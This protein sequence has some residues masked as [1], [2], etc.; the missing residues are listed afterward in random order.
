MAKGSSHDG[1]GCRRMEDIPM[2]NSE[3]VLIAL[4]KQAQNKEYQFHRIYRNLCI[5]DMYIKAYSNIYGNKGS[6]TPGTDGETA[7]GFSE[8][9][10]NRIIDSLKDE[11]YQ[12]T[13]LRRAYIPKKN[14]KLRPLG[15]PSFTDRV[16]QEV[17][18]MILEAIY[19]PSFSGS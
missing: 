8:E 12:A 10:V 7:D 11:S 16:I 9:K 13:P 19:E 6:S 1:L 5:P 4:S 2:M 18:R 3:E 14:G 17:C 15:I